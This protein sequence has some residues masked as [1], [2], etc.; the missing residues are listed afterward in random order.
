MALVMAKARVG[1]SK[2]M[3]VPR[4]ELTAAVSSVKVSKFL[5][6][7]LDL[8]QDGDAV[9]E[10]F[11]TDSKVVLGYINNEAKRFHIFVANRV[12]QIRD[13][14]QPEQW[15]H[16]RTH[17]N[18]ADIASRGISAK[19]LLQ[20]DLWWKGPAFLSSP[21]PVQ[22]TDEASTIRPDDPEVRKTTFCTESHVAPPVEGGIHVLETFEKFSSW[23]R[24]QRAVAVCNKFIKKLRNHDKGH[25]SPVTVADMEQAKQ[26]IIRIV[27]RAEIKALG[28]REHAKQGISS[29]S[30]IFLLDP[31]LDENSLLRALV[32]EL[33]RQIC[34][35][36]SSIQSYY[37][38]IAT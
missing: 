11:W 3:T 36:A 19:E 6:T 25:Y 38:G 7:E 16:I 9:R 10:Y 33:G 13:I 18:P 4:L 14:T 23:F 26:Q 5:K 20:S 34:Q 8:K 30:T 12:Q 32:G 24:L 2:P 29:Q 15:H 27:Q 22:M 37:Q 31:F 28:N 1:P 17:E 21:D 35:K